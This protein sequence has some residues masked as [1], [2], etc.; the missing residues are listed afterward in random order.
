[1]PEEG[2][3]RMPTPGP[4]DGWCRRRPPCSPTARTSLAAQAECT[5]LEVDVEPSQYPEYS[6]NVPAR[7]GNC[8]AACARIRDAGVRQLATLTIAAVS[9]KEG[10]LST[11]SVVSGCRSSLVLV[12]G[13]GAHLYC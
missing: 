13:S 1:G 5:C 4:T 10:G 8:T 7:P 3:L 12:V 2:E 11:G 6:S 9:M